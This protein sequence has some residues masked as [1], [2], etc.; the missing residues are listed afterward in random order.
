MNWQEKLIEIIIGQGKET[1]EDL[2]KLEVKLDNFIASSNEKFVTQKLFRWKVTFVGGIL[3]GA[4]VL[5][6]KTVASV[7]GGR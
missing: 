4:A 5:I 3:G 2:K 1:R 6:V 7:I